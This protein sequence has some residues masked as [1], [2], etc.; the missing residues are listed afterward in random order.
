MKLVIDTNYLFSFFW[1]SSLIKKLLLS[2]HDLYSPEFALEELD[3]HKEEIMQKTKLN[4]DE[5][6]EFITK[7]KK[8]VEFIPFP[9]YTKSVP[10]AYEL[11]PDHP[12]DLDFLALALEMNAALLSK[13][14]ELKKQVKVKIYDDS[15]IS[16]L[17]TLD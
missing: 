17:L 14:K 6:E 12:K 15:E 4:P 10:K 5:F 7:L 3:N 8:I 16:N 2:E 13:D 1:R 9:Q 11:L